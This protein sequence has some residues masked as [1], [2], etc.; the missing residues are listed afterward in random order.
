MAIA[1]DANPPITNA[2]SPPIITSPIRAGTATASA[3]RMS[4]DDRCNVFWMENA[5][6]EAA[7]DDELEELDRRLAKH[8]QEQRE[9]QRGGRRARTAG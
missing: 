9:Q 8:E 2:P 3:V 1:A 5:S 4:G 7:A 6:A